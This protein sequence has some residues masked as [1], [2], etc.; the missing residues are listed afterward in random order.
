MSDM[1]K[2]Q[3]FSFKMIN[4]ILL[5]ILPVL[6][7]SC[8][9]TKEEP[10]FPVSNVYKEKYRPQIHFSSKRNWINDPNGL[11]YLNGEYH[12][13]FQHNPLGAVWGNMSWGHAVSTDLMHWK[14]LNV[15]LMPD[16]LGDIFSGC[17]VIDKNNTAGFGKDAMVAI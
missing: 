17:A 11:V 4:I 7:C 15:A 16:H 3:V 14:Q 2:K 10:E 1:L 6:L 9:K 12:L 8:D 13:F 5:G